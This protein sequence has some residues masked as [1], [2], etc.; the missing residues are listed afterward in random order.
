MCEFES[1]VF[2]ALATA[3]LYSIDTMAREECKLLKNVSE[4]IVRGF[5][6]WVKLKLWKEYVFILAV[7]L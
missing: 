5:L 3:A 1:R 6:Q 2:I 7:I 4:N